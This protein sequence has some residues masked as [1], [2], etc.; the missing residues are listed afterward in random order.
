MLFPERVVGGVPN[1]PRRRL[2]HLGRHL[3]SS[4][5]PATDDKAPPKLYDW[6]AHQAKLPRLPLPTLRDTCLRYLRSVRAL[7]N[8]E[9]HAKTCLAVEEFM[10]PGGRGRIAAPRA[11]GAK[12]QSALLAEP[13]SYVRPFWNDMYLRGRYPLPINSNPAIEIAPPLDLSAR[14]KLTQQNSAAELTARFAQFWLA[15]REHRLPPDVQQGVPF[16]MDEYCRLFEA[17]RHSFFWSRPMER[18]QVC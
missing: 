13:T 17:S 14:P 12:S 9:D 15:M 3:T 2:T 18:G 11:C 8:S 1:A 5:R 6:T 16:C 10:K 7:Q 4:P